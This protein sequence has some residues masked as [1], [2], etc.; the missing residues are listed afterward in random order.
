MKAERWLGEA[1]RATDLDSTV[2]QSAGRGKAV[3]DGLPQAAMQAG[4]VV[5]GHTSGPKLLV[6]NLHMHRLL[7]VR[8]VSAS[9]QLPSASIKGTE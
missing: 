1:R 6:Q 8:P 9:L 5:Q 7:G 3:A 2:Q 4:Q